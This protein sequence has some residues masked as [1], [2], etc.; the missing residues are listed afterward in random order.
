MSRILTISAGAAVLLIVLGVGGVAYGL[1]LEE[2][3]DFCASCHTQ[4]EST[5]YARAQHAPPPDLASIHLAKNVKCIDCHGGAPPV[6]RVAG[7]LQGAHDY[8]LYLSGSY[9]RPALTT[10]PLPDANCVK[11]HNDLFQSRTLNN[12]WHYYLPPWQQALGAQAAACI[13]CHISHSTAQ[14][15]VVKFVPDTKINPIC[16]SCHL[17]QGIR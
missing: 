15:N 4:P 12:H 8:A 2:H 5:Y 7:L 6:D 1:S 3:N 11:C 13:D 14:G 16:Q 10:N 9:H 17:Y